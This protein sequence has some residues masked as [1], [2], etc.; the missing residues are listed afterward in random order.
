[1]VGRLLLASLVCVVLSAC[2]RS[3]AIPELQQ[4]SAEPAAAA[5]IESAPIALV[6]DFVI[7]TPVQHGNLTIF[8][9]L[10]KSIRAEDRFITLNEGLKAGTVEILEMGV[11]PNAVRQSE[12]ASQA[13]PIAS[14]D[15]QS[16]VQV[17]TETQAAEIEALILA[18]NDVSRLMVV[19]RSGKP[20]YLMP[21]EIIV[22]GSQ[23]RTIGE[24]M[25][26][27]PT[28][29]PVPVDVFCVEHGRWGARDATLACEVLYPAFGESADA[30]ALAS[31]A[32][33]GKFVAKAGNLSKSG[34]VAVQAGAGQQKVWDEVA[35]VNNASGVNWSSGAFTANYCDKEV[36]ERLKP[37][38]EALNLSVSQQERVVG[39][40]VAINGKIET[41][42]VFES[43]PL[44]LKL[45]PQ[46]L[47]SYALDAA[48][49]AGAEDAGKPVVAGEAE[50]FL[51]SVLRD[52]GTETRK[53]EGGLVVSR[54]ETND[55]ISFSAGG[56]G[57]GLVGGFGDTVHAA[58]Y[59]K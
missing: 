32:D 44:F 9:V 16:A 13:A 23:D 24:E 29:E 33:K 20:L 2:G 53:M 11:R 54:H 51:A 56:M 57:G 12:G 35:K 28:G 55:R 27:A 42:D 17:D 15:E 7:S 5:T 25:V 10:S 37:Y 46:L 31:K 26:I 48:Q 14:E 43:T 3:A 22:G 36:L 30:A 19:N 1:M 52:Q 49:V 4:S 50:A 6:D 21:G 40:V 45:W 47:Q 41:V 59:S 39:V 34:R 58:A 38:Q 8:P 18:R